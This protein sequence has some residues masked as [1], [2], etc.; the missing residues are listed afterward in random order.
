MTRF[1]Y[2]PVLHYA[3]NAWID[4]GKHAEAMQQVSFGTAALFLIG[5]GLDGNLSAEDRQGEFKKPFK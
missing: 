5:M 1:P 2:N 3:F 4:K